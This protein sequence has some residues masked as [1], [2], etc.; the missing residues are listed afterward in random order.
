MPTAADVLDH[1]FL[2]ARA[3]ILI[4]AAILDRI[5]RAD[6]TVDDDPRIDQLR[7]AMTL[8]LRPGSDRAEA[9][10]LLLS[11]PYNESWREE[12]GIA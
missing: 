8:L 3:K 5:D 12:Y 11:L 1:E 6:G 10:Q 2:D 7:E 9:V 4:L